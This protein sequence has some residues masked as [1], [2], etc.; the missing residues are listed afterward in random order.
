MA[1]VR[2]LNEIFNNI[3][4]FKLQ[5]KKKNQMAL[6]FLH[7]IEKE[8]NI[9]HQIKLGIRRTELLTKRNCNKLSGEYVAAFCK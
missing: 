1:T 6:I 4:N 5:C 9:F 2:I 8:R 3:Q 7:Y